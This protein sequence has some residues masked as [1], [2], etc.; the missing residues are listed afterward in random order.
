LIVKFPGSQFKGRRVKNNVR[1]IDVLPTVLGEIGGDISPGQFEG[2]DLKPLLKHPE[3]EERICYAEVRTVPRIS[4]IEKNHKS[5][6]NQA[7]GAGLDEVF[8]IPGPLELYNLKEDPGERNN[9]AEKDKEI[10]SR[11]LRHLDLYYEKGR[12]KN[13]QP[14]KKQEVPEELKEV[15]RSLGY[16][17]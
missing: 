6:I 11:F 1:I 16:I 7:S 14:G 5:I 10:A 17:K 8:F 4:I 3:G 2:A 9:L 15:L 13:P 12:Q